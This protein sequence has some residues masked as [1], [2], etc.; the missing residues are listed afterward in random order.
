MAD[1]RV[2]PTVPVHI[3]ATPT[4]VMAECA[5][6]GR[7]AECAVDDA[8]GGPATRRKVAVAAAL[9][10]LREQC[11]LRLPWGPVPPHVERRVPRGLNVFA[12]DLHGTLW[13]LSVND[14]GKLETVAGG[15]ALT[16]LVKVV[17]ERASEKLAE[18]A[19]EYARE[20]VRRGYRHAV[21]EAAGYAGRATVEA[22]S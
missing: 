15:C 6:C 2:P 13:P 14:K 9:A 4:L 3:D 18:A 12:E 10:S 21:A 16:A 22:K 5:R 7:K 17:P 1:D 11:E 19:T 20:L 8:D